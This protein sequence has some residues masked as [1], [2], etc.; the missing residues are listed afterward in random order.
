MPACVYNVVMKLDGSLLDN[1][2]RAAASARRLRGHPVYKDTLI[3]WTELLQEA[4]RVRL[5]ADDAH[6]A[7]LEAA[8]VKLE[9]ELAER[10]N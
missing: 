4:R 2:E 5:D 9:V 6:R 7:Q 1:L 10:A 8:I 3:Y